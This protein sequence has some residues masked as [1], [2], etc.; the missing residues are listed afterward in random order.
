MVQISA[1]ILA[2]ILGISIL[3]AFASCANESDKQTTTAAGEIKQESTTA[4][5]GK[6]TI[7]ASA[8]YN[9]STFNIIYPVW[10]LYRDYY[11]AEEEGADAITNALYNRLRMIEE[12]L[13]VDIKAVPSGGNSDILPAIRTAVQSGDKSVDLALTHCTAGTNA[14][15]TEGLVLDWNSIPGVDTSRPYWNKSMNDTL[16]VNGAL[17]LAANDFILPDPNAILF[18]KAMLY[19][20]GLESPYLLVTSGQWTWDKLTEMAKKASEDL[21]GDGIY[22]NKDRYGFEAELDWMLVSIMHSCDQYLVTR[23]ENGVPI[24]DLMTDKMSNIID[25]TRTLLFDD[26][27][28]HAFLRTGN[29]FMT[30]QKF[31]NGQSLFIM[32]SLNHAS[33]YRSFDFDFGILPYPKYDTSQKEYISTNWAGLMAVPNNVDNPEKSGLVAELLGYYG[34]KDVLPA[35]KEILLK[36]KI[37]RDDDSIEMLDIIYNNSVYDFGINFGNWMDC[38]YVIPRLMQNKSDPLASFLEMNQPPYQTYLEET[39]YGILEAAG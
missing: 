12:E 8:N 24:V 30:T 22:T 6:P 13:K 17:Y 26:N 7:P 2:C 14:I 31:S 21:D 27:T 23:D 5:D 4:S 19:D 10:G 38:E 20:L 33:A 36:S 35:Y 28:S 1:R 18:N 37:T 34:N 32:D 11:F 9:N 3:S 15:A 29:D 25:K 39:Y 16:A